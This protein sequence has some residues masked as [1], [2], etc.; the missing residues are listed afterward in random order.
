MT[1]FPSSILLIFHLILEFSTFPAWS[2]VHLGPRQKLF[3]WMYRLEESHQNT[4]N[5]AFGMQYISLC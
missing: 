2:H 1:E 4:E 3:Y 5:N